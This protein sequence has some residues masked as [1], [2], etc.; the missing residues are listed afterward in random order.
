MVYQDLSAFTPA[1][2][3]KD[4]RK[5]LTWGKRHP[6]SAAERDSGDKALSARREAV[7]ARL[8]FVLAGKGVHRLIHILHASETGP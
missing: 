1:N 3:I 8:T 4:A 6:Q 5:V 7:D 2:T